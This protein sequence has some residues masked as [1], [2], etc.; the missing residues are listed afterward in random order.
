MLNQVMSDL[1]MNS[2]KMWV[3]AVE[4]RKQNKE[5]ASETREE[6]ALAFVDHARLKALPQELVCVKLKLAFN[7]L[8]VCKLASEHP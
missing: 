1:V 4:L 8:K 3:E 5:L 2:K 6:E 7:L